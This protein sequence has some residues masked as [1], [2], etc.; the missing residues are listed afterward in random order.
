VST[1]VVVPKR[2]EGCKDNLNCLSS[3]ITS[4]MMMGQK[5]STWCILF[6]FHRIP[7]GHD[8]GARDDEAFHYPVNLSEAEEIAILRVLCPCRN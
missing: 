5:R 1:T 7:M 3:V 4:Y 6:A 8:D 2:A